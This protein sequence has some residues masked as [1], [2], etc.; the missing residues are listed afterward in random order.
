MDSVCKTKKVCK[1]LEYHKNIW[2]F[3]ALSLK[4]GVLN[5]RCFKFN[6]DSPD[7]TKWEP[8][9]SSRLCSD[10]FQGKQ[11]NNHPHHIDSVPSIHPVS[12]L[13]QNTGALA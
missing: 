12:V 4:V 1:Y 13:K 6:N 10:H 7:G 11:K 8:E 2:E 3:Y 5:G 9:K